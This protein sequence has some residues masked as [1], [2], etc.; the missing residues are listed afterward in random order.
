MVRQPLIQGWRVGVPALLSR[1]QSN[2]GWSNDIGAS[3]DN[4][5]SI[6]SLLSSPDLTYYSVFHMPKHK[7]YTCFVLDVW[8]QC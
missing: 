4:A 7:H 3:E 2:S 6:V 5:E 8:N 1:L